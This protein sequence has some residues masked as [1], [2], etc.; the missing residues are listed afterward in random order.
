MAYRF[1]SRTKRILLCLKFIGLANSASA[2]ISASWSKRTFGPDGPWPAIE[3]NIAD[4]QTITIY[5]GNQSPLAYVF[6]DEYCD[7][8]LTSPCFPAQAGLYNVDES[9]SV[10]PE[11]DSGF[12]QSY[13]SGVDVESITYRFRADTVDFQKGMPIPNVMMLPMN[14]SFAEYPDGTWYP[15]SVGCLGLGSARQGEG[16]GFFS[17]T[18]ATNTTNV[19][20][21]TIPG[22]LSDHEY[23]SSNSFGM[24]LGSSY[25]KM[26]GSLYLGGYD[27]NRLIGDVMTIGHTSFLAPQVA[28]EDISIQVVEGA[29]PWGFTTRDGL[30]RQANDTISPDGLLMYVDSCSPYFSL[31]KSTCDAITSYLPV[32]YNEKLGLYFWDTDSANYSKIVYSASS[33]VFT[34]QP[35][36][37]DNSTKSENITISVPFRHLNLTLEPPLVPTTQQYFPCYT[38]TERSVYTLGRAFLQDAFLGAN[39]DSDT[40]WLAQA[41]GPNVRDASIVEIGAG[42]ISIG[43]SSMDWKESWSGHWKALT[44]EEAAATT[45]ISP[46]I[47]TNT[48]GSGIDKLPLPAKAGIGMGVGVFLLLLGFFT[49]WKIVQSRKQRNKVPTDI[50][51]DSEETPIE[52]PQLHPDRISSPSPYQME[53]NQRPIELA[54]CEIIELEDTQIHDDKKTN[55]IDNFSVSPEKPTSMVD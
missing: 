49:A 31:P 53:D 6:T 22:Y 46:P 23:I 24:H 39:W 13:M 45:S 21:S 19:N 44:P 37:I 18:N 9:A 16:G 3:I 28:L 33:L 10:S 42:D 2:P 51:T 27:Q 5:P 15:L 40:E 43:S 4:N 20:T 8:N 52:K 11:S 48:A 50:A 55:S 7:N 32:T 30:L 36:N 14:A 25:P 34:L 47:P 1:S 29:S 12:W 54:Q 17:T 26:D 35:F 38:G 41:P